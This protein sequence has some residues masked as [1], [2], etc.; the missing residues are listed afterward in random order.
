MHS[1][2][3]LLLHSL[4][5]SYV[6]LLIAALGY[7]I[8]RWELLPKELVLP[9]YATMAPYQGY[10]TVNTELVVEGQTDEGVWQQ[11]DIH[12]YVPSGRGEFSY[13]GFMLKETATME[14]RND[15]Y[16]IFARHVQRLEKERGREWQ[17][18]RLILRE[19]PKSPHGY[20]VLNTPENQTDTHLF[21]L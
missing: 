18:V 11:I 2:R 7:T 15:R 10:T 4:L 8:F 12:S 14:Q 20:H 17:S 16:D 19:W 21:T 3:H 6:V 1:N 9:V 5:L 13:R